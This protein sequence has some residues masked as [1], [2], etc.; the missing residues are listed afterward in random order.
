MIDM[1]KGTPNDEWSEKIS[2]IGLKG[3]ARIHKG[4]PFKSVGDITAADL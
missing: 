4:D 3:K 2:T 1:V